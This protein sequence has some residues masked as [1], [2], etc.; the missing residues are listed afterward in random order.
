MLRTRRGREYARQ[1]PLKRL[2]TETDLPAE[3]QTGLSADMVDGAILQ[4][5]AELSR[6]RGADVTDAV[7]QNSEQLLSP[8]S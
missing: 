2:L 4:T 1:L 5:L 7:G 3:D 8:I 6:I